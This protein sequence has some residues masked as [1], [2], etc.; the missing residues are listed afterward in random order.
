MSFFICPIYTFKHAYDNGRLF[1]S[2]CNRKTQEI[3]AGRKGEGEERERG[4]GG[5]GRGIQWLT[6]FSDV[7]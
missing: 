6:L 2:K 1:V 3:L 5:G 4:E 7:L